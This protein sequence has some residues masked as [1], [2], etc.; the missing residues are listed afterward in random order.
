LAA[1]LMLWAFGDWPR[2]RNFAL[3]F[4]ATLAVLIAG[5]QLLLPNWMEQFRQAISEYRQYNDGALSVLQVLTSPLWGGVLAMLALL[6][7]ARLCWKLR[8]APAGSTAFGWITVLVLAVTILVA[9]KTSPYNHILLLPG[10]LLAAQHWRIAWGRSSATRVTF[11]VAAFVLFWPWIAALP[12]AIFSMVS[13][14][15]ALPKAWIT[16]VYTMLAIPFAVC[17]LLAFNLR[18]LAESISE[19][20][21][22][23]AIGR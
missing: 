13:P 21:P 17:V 2:R 7:L 20:K 1:W 19:M 10:V 9:P 12:L 14:A 18:V 4:G 22:A 23:A 6:A 16:P 11:L 8:R 3:A 5:A 15:T